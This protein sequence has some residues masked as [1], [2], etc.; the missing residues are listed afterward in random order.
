MIE[1]LDTVRLLSDKVANVRDFY[2]DECSGRQPSLDCLE[3][4]SK[5]C[6][7]LATILEHVAEGPLS[8]PDMRRVMELIEECDRMGNEASAWQDSIEDALEEQ[9][10]EIS[11]LYSDY[12]PSIVDRCWGSMTVSESVEG[13]DGDGF[14]TN[15]ESAAR[16]ILDQLS[17]SC[18][19]LAAEEA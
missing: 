3:H 1:S 5:R 14:A 11:N 9:R 13:L 12:T 16:R 18:D 7:E 4:T 19:E 10:Y 6:V 15:D 17:R 2:K 8:G